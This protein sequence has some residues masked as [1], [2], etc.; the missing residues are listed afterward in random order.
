MHSKHI[1]VSGKVVGRFG[2]KMLLEQRA[3]TVVD[4]LPGHIFI[5]VRFNL[6]LEKTLV[7]VYFFV[8]V[9]GKYIVVKELNA[10]VW[11]VELTLRAHIPVFPL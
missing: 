5:L 7:T 8:L 2:L 3:F 10:R 1:L 4:E 11:Q 9:Y 6:V